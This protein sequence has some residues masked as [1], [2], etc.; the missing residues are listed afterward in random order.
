MRENFHILLLEKT[1]KK[2]ILSV[3]DRSL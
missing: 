2:K 3:Q 1:R